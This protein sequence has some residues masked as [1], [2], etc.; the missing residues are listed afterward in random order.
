[1]SVSV[2][3]DDCDVVNSVISTLEPAPGGTTHVT[4]L[5]V[6]KC[7][8]TMHTDGPTMM[9]IGHCGPGILLPLIRT[10]EPP[11]V[12]GDG[13]LSALLVPSLTN[14]SRGGAMPTRPATDTFCPPTLTTTVIA[15][16]TLSGTV[17]LMAIDDQEN[18]SHGTSL[19][20]AV[21]LNFRLSGF[22]DH[23]DSE[24]EPGAIDIHS[25]TLDSR[26]RSEHGPLP[27]LLPAIVII[28]P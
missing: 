3:T 2:F 16:S 13:G 24:L 9:A 11:A 14:D 21:W 5:F 18:R 28:P 4:L 17:Q 22:N 19:S 12:D 26:R 8:T 15:A 23:D 25:C 1:M 20:V 6:R 7:S 27:K 10:N